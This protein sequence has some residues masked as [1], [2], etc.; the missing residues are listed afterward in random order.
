M[1]FI[2]GDDANH[3]DN[4]RW[5][6]DGLTLKLLRSP[7]DYELYVA[8]NNVGLVKLN[9][10]FSTLASPFWMTREQFALFGV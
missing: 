7:A 2:V 10:A 5:I 3:A 6:C 1:L 4:R 9:P 8:W